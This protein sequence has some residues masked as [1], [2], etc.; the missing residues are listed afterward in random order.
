MIRNIDIDLLRAFVTVYECGGFSHAADRLARTQSTVSHQIKKLESILGKELFHRST[1]SIEMTTEGEVLLTYAKKMISLNDEA[2]GR[3]TDADISGVVRLGATEAF[4][5]NHLADVLFQF[6]KTHPSVRLEVDCDLSHN[7]IERYEKGNYD[8]ILIKRDTKTKIH[9]NKVWKE[10][11]IWVSNQRFELESDRV[12]PLVLSPA[13]CVYR[14]KMLHALE[15]R[16]INW[17]S[18]FTSTSMHGR[19]AAA[20]SGL[21]ITA[22]PKEMLSKTSNLISL[23]HAKSGLPPLP[24]IEIDLLQNKETMSDAAL[25]LAEHIIFALEHEPTL[26]S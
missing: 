3:I 6:S 26:K 9:G 8:L 1:R 11:L 24:S 7:L 25:R 12:V 15:K 4:A 2:F 19:I 20:R 23:E 5:A 18:V 21:G 16:K 13:P 22:I 10:A 14:G 17:S